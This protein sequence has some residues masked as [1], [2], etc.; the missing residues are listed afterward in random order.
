MPD[1]IP[2]RAGRLDPTTGA[3]ERTDGSV[4]QLTTKERQ[5]AIHLAAHPSV[6][7]ERQ[8]LLAEVWGYAPT[9][10][11]RALDTTIKQ[12]RQKL[13]V[14][15]RQPDHIL[16]VWGCGY[17]FEPLTVDEPSHDLLGRDDALLT[18]QGLLARPGV[19][20]LTGP[21]GVGKS[22]LLLAALARRNMVFV[23]LD[24]VEPGAIE[25]AVER[26]LPPSDAPLGSR[27]ATLD[28]TLVL[29]DAEHLAATL[30]D[31][32]GRWRTRCPGLTLAI[33]SRIDLDL[34]ARRMEV[35]P[36]EPADTMQLLRRTS[37]DR[38]TD[39]AILAELAAAVDGLPLAAELIAPWSLVL[40]KD[41]LIVRAD[42]LVS[43]TNGRAR[44]MA[45]VVRRSVDLLPPEVRTTLTA[46]SCFTGAFEAAELEQVHP[47][48]DG[49][50]HL[51]ALRSASLVAAA[52]G[53]RLR[54]LPL[55][56]RLVRVLD[57][58]SLPLRERFATCLV[59]W[60]GGE[61]ST[62]WIPALERSYLD[63]ELPDGLRSRL[64]IT[65]FAITSRNRSPLFDAT[66]GR[67]VHRLSAADPDPDVVADGLFVRN[68]LS[69]RGVLPVAKELLDQGVHQAEPAAA[70]RR[71][72][73]RGVRATYDRLRRRSS[74]ED[75][76]VAAALQADHPPHVEGV[77]AW[78]ELGLLH[79]AEG[80]YDQ[81]R[82]AMERACQLARQVDDPATLAM[83]CF[84]RAATLQVI[85]HPRPAL[86]V[87]DQ[88]HRV[89]LTHG[90]PAYADI[91]QRGSC[92][93]RHDLG[94]LDGAE[95]I[96]S[97][98]GTFDQGFFP[99]SVLCFRALL[100]IERHELSVALELVGRARGFV[101]SLDGPLPPLVDLV[102]GITRAGCGDPDAVALLERATRVPVD[103]VRTI[104]AVWLAALERGPVPSASSPAL[105]ALVDT[106]ARRGQGPGPRVGAHA[107]ILHAWWGTV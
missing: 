29:D 18:L 51:L 38:L 53:G 84:R 79:R 102:E 94:D 57:P 45:D 31:I 66:F 39:P 14:D 21:G 89:A 46:C 47:D 85:G 69:L 70:W 28:A 32:V 26:C 90:M 7:I 93:A 58:P 34:P 74:R 23:A 12:L 19:V 91:I 13:E 52:P 48:P 9:V 73:A 100:A 81:A 68:A 3:F 105:S 86:V 25:E 96:L 49:L 40:P 50:D 55:L 64:G 83:A 82:E 27:L 42:E 15:R 92:P 1:V 97:S 61:E 77:R 5:L 54:M 24:S 20:L 98:P 60:A 63:T 87:F 10:R 16:T 103:T 41:D 80:S 22:S 88:A 78:T 8:V 101:T 72:R 56:R 62:R 59:E 43:R 30:P 44:S 6:D 17:R 106:L 107:R 36:L 99:G 11:T 2:F 104:A 95:T 65:L 67:T 37:G 76:E 33:T 35:A 4:V 75:L 71:M